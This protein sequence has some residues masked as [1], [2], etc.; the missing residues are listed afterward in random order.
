VRVLAGALCVLSVMMV[1]MW[2][3]LLLDR[4][5][6]HPAGLRQACI[7]LAFALV[8]APFMAWTIRRPGPDREWLRLGPP[9][10]GTG[11]RLFR[12]AALG[13]LGVVAAAL[14]CSLLPGYR[15]LAESQAELGGWRTPAELAR[16]A[17]F[18]AAMPAWFEELYFRG[19]LLDRMRREWGPR[20]ALLA[21]AALFAP[22]HGPAAPVAAILGLVNGSLTMASGSLWPGIV[23]HFL[24]NLTVVVAL[25]GR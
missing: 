4:S 1:A 3:L 19:Y 18:L 22:L 21:Q 6:G 25:R 7:P 23:L 24:N 14:L 9:A 15:N 10:P 2:L 12:I 13:F 17:V 8:A 5:L 20:V 16:N 11:W